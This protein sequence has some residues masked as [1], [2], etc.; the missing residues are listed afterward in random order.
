MYISI[1]V[2]VFFCE[3]LKKEYT[4]APRSFGGGY[5]DYIGG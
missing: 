5:T 4:Y 1:Y 2:E 3:S